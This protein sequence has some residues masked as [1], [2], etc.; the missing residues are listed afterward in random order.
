MQAQNFIFSRGEEELLARQMHQLLPKSSS[1]VKQQRASGF[2]VSIMRSWRSAQMTTP[3]ALKFF[4]NPDNKSKRR[5]TRQ[6]VLSRTS[7]QCQQL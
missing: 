3:Q 4:N 5:T 1:E 7:L 6:A 2:P